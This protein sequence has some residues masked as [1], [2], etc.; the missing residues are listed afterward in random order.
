MKGNFFFELV[1]GSF[2][3]ANN[4]KAAEQGDS[5]SNSNSGSSSLQSRWMHDQ[6]CGSVSELRGKWW[7]VAV[8]FD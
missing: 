1:K 8:R 6:G 4:V 2:Y 3:N 7:Y 5:K